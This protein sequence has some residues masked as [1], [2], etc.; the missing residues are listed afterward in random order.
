M[1]P[2]RFEAQFDNQ[3]CKFWKSLYELNQSL[4]AWFDT[5]TTF[6]KSQR[7]NQGHSDHTLFIKISKTEKIVVLSVYVDDIMLSEDDH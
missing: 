6:I 2:S 7:Y 5:F 4:R 1:S 3:V